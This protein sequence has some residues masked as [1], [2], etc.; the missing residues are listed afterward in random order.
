MLITQIVLVGIRAQAI[1]AGGADRANERFQIVMRID[2]ILGQAV[3]EFLVAGRVGYPHIIFWFDQCRGKEMLPI[4]IDQS[5]SEERIAGINHPINQCLP[6]VIGGTQGSDLRIESGRLQGLAGLGMLG[7][8]AAHARHKHRFV[9][10]RSLLALHLGKESRHVK[11]IA[12]APLFKRMVMAAR[13]LNALAQEQLSSILHT[14]LG[15]GNF[16]EPCDR[17]IDID[18]SRRG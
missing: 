1:G 6:R 11:V 13:A 4:S 10:C 3:E 15:T 5:P 18:G 17:R 9:G 14:R 7:S 2:E 16:M 12:L 8:G